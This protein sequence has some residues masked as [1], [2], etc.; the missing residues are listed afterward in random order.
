MNIVERKA[1]G[2]ALLA[3]A[4]ALVAGREAG[5][6][7][8]FSEHDNPFDQHR[9]PDQHRAWRRGFWVGRSIDEHPATLRINNSPLF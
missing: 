4:E 9:A 8:A 7:D 3:M 1:K 6:V 5:H 2:H